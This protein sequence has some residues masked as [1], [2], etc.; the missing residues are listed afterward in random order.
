MSD[1]KRIDELRELY[2]TI[3]AFG[4]RK[5]PS[6]KFMMF[7]NPG[8]KLVMMLGEPVKFRLCEGGV[9]G[10]FRLPEDWV[11]LHEPLGEDDSV[12]VARQLETDRTIKITSYSSKTPES[13]VV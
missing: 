6:D 5:A 10:F 1:T 8:N 3:A 7:M 12:T 13:E 4:E 11:S 2:K 9:Q